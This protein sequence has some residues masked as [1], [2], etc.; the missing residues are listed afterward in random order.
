MSS[1]FDPSTPFDL[2]A[3][4]DKTVPPGRPRAS[5]IIEFGETK[6]NGRVFFDKITHKRVHEFHSS[7]APLN[8]PQVPGWRKPKKS[9]HLFRKASEKVVLRSLTGANVSPINTLVSSAEGCSYVT[10]Y[11]FK[12]TKEGEST[13]IYAPGN[14]PLYRKP[15]KDEFPIKI[16]TD[17]GKHYIDEHAGR[18]PE[19]QYLPMLLSMLV[20]NREFRFDK[21]K[22]NV[23][24]NRS[25]LEQL[26]KFIKGAP[27]QPYH[28][29]LTMEGDTLFIGKKGSFKGSSAKGSCGR[30]FEKWLTTEDPDFEDATG[31]HRFIK[32]RFGDLVM[33]VRFEVDAYVAEEHV[34]EDTDRPPCHYPDVP[35]PAV[36]PEDLEHPLCTVIPKGTLIKQHQLREL[37][38]GTTKRPVQQMWLGRTPN[39]TIT[40]GK[41]IEEGDFVSYD[42]AK[43]RSEY[44]TQSGENGFENW[45]M[46]QREKDP[47][48]PKAWLEKLAELLHK[49]I[50]ATK[51]TKDRSAVLVCMGTDKTLNVYEAKERIEVAPKDIVAKF[52][53]NDEEEIIPHS[54]AAV[55]RRLPWYFL[56]FVLSLCIVWC[57]IPP[58]N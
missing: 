4:L 15:H 27:D 51:E 6:E 33:I 52:W 13:A 24:A 11:S 49:L 50:E 43:F 34:P 21:E 20:T 3:A 38:S 18:C 58:W 22:I 44:A 14:P 25:S 7:K 29:E 48:Q 1:P 19:Y 41:Y 42:W 47:K 5:S 46:D 39:C 56:C 37:K 53:S 31:H 12:D 16:P 32:Y 9:E 55:R 40:K 2:S 28:L 8:F 23:V 30:N 26:I 45:E 57:F 10:S 35:E 54:A 17:K 36:T